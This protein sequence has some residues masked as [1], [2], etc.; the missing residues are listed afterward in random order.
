MT[1][2]RLAAIEDRI[3]RNQSHPDIPELA[4]ELI[5]ALKAR[6]TSPPAS[7]TSGSTIEPAEIRRPS[8]EEAHDEDEG[9]GGF[10]GLGKKKK[11]K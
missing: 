5:A 10:L 4:L 7:P 1:P 2:E 3:R 9:G 6:M 11:S 8:H